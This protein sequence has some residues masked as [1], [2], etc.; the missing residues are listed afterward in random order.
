MHLIWETK[1]QSVFVREYG[2]CNQLSSRT[3]RQVD[4]SIVES[5]K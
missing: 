3:G 4:T 5:T 1:Y 2:P